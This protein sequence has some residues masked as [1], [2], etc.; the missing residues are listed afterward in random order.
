[1]AFDPR[2]IPNRAHYDRLM[3]W[4]TDVF[5]R[6]DAESLS[7]IQGDLFKISEAA[8]TSTQTDDDTPRI[9]AVLAEIGFAAVIDNMADIIEESTNGNA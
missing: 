9:A 4:A 7:Q 1:M 6:L 3:T 8:A 2:A 5:G